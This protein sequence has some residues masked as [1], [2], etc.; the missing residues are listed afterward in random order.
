M[1]DDQGQHP[2]DAPNDAEAALGS[3]L[4]A[5]R[6]AA[7]LGTEA[8]AAALHLDPE[9]VAALEAESFESLGAPVFV[10]GHV[11]ALANHLELDP[12]EAMRRYEATAGETGVRPPDLVVQYQR[13]I[14]RNRLAPALVVAIVALLTIALVTVF[15][16]W[17]DGRARSREP[18]RDAGTDVGVADADAAEPTDPAQS[19]APATAAAPQAVPSAADSESSDFAARLAEARARSA[20]NV[21][22]APEPVVEQ[23]AAERTGLTLRFSGECWFE[24]RDANGR[25]LATGTAAPGET[26]SVDGARPLS[27]T[28]GVA[29]A[30]ALTLDGSPVEI[31][32][33]SRRGRSARMTLR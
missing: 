5:A 32:A 4:R 8:V 1:S 7:G 18:V 9:V 2:D 24:V 23:P 13:P 21:T 10:R 31:P 22:R 33:E 17:P 27:V 14:R 30:V 19:M 26:R 28:L 29:D 3:W 15:L 20:A 6:E 11:R 12:K 16:L 25:R